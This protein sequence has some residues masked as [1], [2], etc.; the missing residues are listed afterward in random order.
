MMKFKVWHFF[1]MYF[2]AEAKVVNFCPLFLRQS[3]FDVAP[4]FLIIDVIVTK[5]ARYEEMLWSYDADD[6]VSGV[7]ARD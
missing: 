6:D 2:L 1:A 3:A 4:C 7:A 5:T